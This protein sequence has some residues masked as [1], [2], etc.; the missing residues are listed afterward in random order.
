M[1]AFFLFWKNFTRLKRSVLYD[2]IFTVN[3]IYL[4]SSSRSIVARLRATLMQLS[5]SAFIAHE[6][7]AEVQMI[8]PRELSER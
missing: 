4:G 2:R 8:A 1:K 6:Q 7:L 3:F 5:Q